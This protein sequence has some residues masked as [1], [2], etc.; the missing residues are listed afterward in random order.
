MGKKKLNVKFKL[1]EK[2]GSLRKSSLEM[3]LDY[4][5]LSQFINGWL[6][7][8]PEEIKKIKNHLGPKVA[9]QAG[10]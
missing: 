9:A 8:K 1:Q 10:L 7:L 4:W 5:R 6:Q 3:G 2:D